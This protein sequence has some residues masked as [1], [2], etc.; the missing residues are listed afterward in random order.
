MLSD[1]SLAI[2]S[3][4]NRKTR[5]QIM[6]LNSKRFLDRLVSTLEE[7]K[8]HEVKLKEGLKDLSA[9][10]MELQNSLTS[11]WPKQKQNW[12]RLR[13]AFEIRSFLGLAG[14]YRRFVKDFSALAFPL[15]R[16]TRNGV[17][18]VWDELCEKSFLELK[19]RLTTTSSSHS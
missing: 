17:K 11:L 19:A 2:S 4:T 6:I 9:K 7:K 12:K 13:N 10:R 16:L 15:T 8:H 3:L 5:D 14:Y 1:V 18:F